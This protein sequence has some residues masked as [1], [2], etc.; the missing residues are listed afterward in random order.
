MA[1]SST[2]ALVT[3]GGSGLGA[4]AAERLATDGFHVIVSDLDPTAAEATVRRIRD[5]DLT[6]SSAICDVTDLAAVEDAMCHAVEV[7][8]RLAAVVCSAGID[9]P[10]APTWEL[11][12]NE[13]G[14]VIATNLTG[15]F[16]ACRVLVPLMLPHRYGR[17][18][19]IASI[20]GKEGNPNLAAYSASKGGVIAFAKALGK[21]LA[22]S[23]IAVNA[24]APAVIETA[25]V[26]RADP[27]MLELLR[28]KIPMGRLGQPAEVAALISW[29][30]SPE[31]SFSTGAVYDISGGRAT[32]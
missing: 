19:M 3:G 32:Y 21:E 11:D 29:L 5:R 9:H 2:V 25:M 10:P 6:A 28:N 13:W 7:A 1:S 8:G 12:P 16:N 23:G 22:T 15:V 27:E 26:A 17:V 4:A 31:C 20:A 24:I 18:V 14:R 30:C